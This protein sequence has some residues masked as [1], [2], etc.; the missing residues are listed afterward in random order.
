LAGASVVITG[1]TPAGYNG[2]FTVVSVDPGVSFTVANATTGV[3]TGTIVFTRNGPVTYT[4][5]NTYILGQIVSITG[6]NPGA[7]NLG[8]QTITSVSSTQFTVAN[9]ATGTYVSGGT[10]GGAFAAGGGGGGFIAAGSNASGLNGGNGGDGGA[11]GGGGAPGGTGGT[12][13]NGVIYLYY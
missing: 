13:G 7:Y 8:D 1:A 6:V 4:A 10:A 9:T 11:G 5:A 2:T 3:A 12:G